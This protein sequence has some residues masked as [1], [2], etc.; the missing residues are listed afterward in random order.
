MDRQRIPDRYGTG[1]LRT[2]TDAPAEVILGVG[3]HRQ[4]IAA[5][6]DLAL[7][8]DQ[9]GVQGHFFHRC[10][11]SAIVPHRG[12]IHHVATTVMQGDDIL[13]VHGERGEAKDG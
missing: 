1:I 13:P 12:A 11:G 10:I 4:L 8:G 5:N 3:I 6:V 7:T 9:G 2:I